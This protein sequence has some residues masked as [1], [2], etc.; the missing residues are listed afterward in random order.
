[1]LMQTTSR[2][3]GVWT[4]I[5]DKANAVREIWTDISTKSTTSKSPKSATNKSPKLPTNVSTLDEFDDL[6]VVLSILTLK[7][8]IRVS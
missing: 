2:D 8:L 7:Q 3:F 1:M 5:A 4:Q 6:A